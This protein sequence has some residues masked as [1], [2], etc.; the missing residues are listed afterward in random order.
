MGGAGGA[1]V[2]GLFSGPLVDRFGPKR[3]MLAGTVVAG[4]GALLLL[5]VPTLNG[6]RL[7]LAAV[8]MGSIAVGIAFSRL[9]WCATRPRWS[10]ST[11]SPSPR[12]YV[13]TAIGSA[14][15]AS[16]HK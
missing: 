9:S 7:G 10:G 13:S 3:A 6:L 2:A 11:S 1:I 5:L 8:S 14:V 15:G 4:V 16:S 12:V